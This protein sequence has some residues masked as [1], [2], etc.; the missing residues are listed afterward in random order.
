MPWFSDVNIGTRS[1]SRHFF[2]IAKAS[3]L[4]HWQTRI[5]RF[6]FSAVPPF[7]PVVKGVDDTSNFVEFEKEPP[8][9]SIENFKMKREFSGNNLPFVGFT[10]VHDVDVVSK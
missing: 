10:Y 4:K 3:N 2:L 8:I 9:P 6:L 7:V 5:T 1:V